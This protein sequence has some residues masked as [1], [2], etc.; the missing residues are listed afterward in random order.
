MIEVDPTLPEVVQRFLAS[1]ARLEEIRLDARGRWW[2]QGG[3]IENRRVVELFSRS[4]N[5]T[6]GGTWVLEVGRYTYPIVVEDTPFFVESFQSRGTGER[7]T[8][9][10]CLVGGELAEL[11]PD[12]L[13]YDD[14]LGVSCAVRSGQFR[15]RFLLDAYHALA[16]RL[17]DCDEGYALVVAGRPVQL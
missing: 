14:G 16:D 17:V 15:A 7:E 6:T 3:R 8:I 5:R 2:H 1:G 10:L 4:V 11:D 12:S 9:T 13:R